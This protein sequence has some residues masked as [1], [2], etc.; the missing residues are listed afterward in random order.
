MSLEIFKSKNQCKPK[1]ARRRR[2]KKRRRRNVFTHMLLWYSYVKLC[3]LKIDVFFFTNEIH[4]IV[5]AAC[6]VPQVTM[7]FADVCAILLL[8]V[9]SVIVR[10]TWRPIWEI[11]KRAV[12]PAKCALAIPVM[13]SDPTV[14]TTK[15]FLYVV[16]LLFCL[17]F[18][19]VRILPHW[20][21]PESCF[22]PSTFKPSLITPVVGRCSEFPVPTYKKPCK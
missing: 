6:V 20:R 22:F 2:R 1:C 19:Q 3:I 10:F 17:D 8:S 12:H 14:I 7:T 5:G 21:A 18:Y 11:N 13:S 9:L 4:I 15:L 16:I